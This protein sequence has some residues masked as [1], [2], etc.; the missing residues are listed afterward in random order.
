MTE[1]VAAAILALAT[2]RESLR[3]EH[4]FEQESDSSCGLAAM[5]TLLTVFRGLPVRE[6]ELARELAGSARVNMGDLARLSEERGL[7]ARGFK[8]DYEQ[9]SEA[10]D[11][12]PPGIAHYS[13][14]T[15]HFV[16][17][18]QS[19]ATWVVVADPSAG[20]EI[21]DREEFSRRWSGAILLVAETVDSEAIAAVEAACAPALSRQRLLG[22][23]APW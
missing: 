9:L 2:P 4:V 19:R 21:V 13:A 3:F 15:A 1:L 7:A 23:W 20:V 8:M 17:V 11:V 22:L 14:P 12:L 10:L 6:A 16:L 5:A 18:L